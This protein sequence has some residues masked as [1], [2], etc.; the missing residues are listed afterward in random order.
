MRKSALI[1]SIF[2]ILNILVMVLI[3]NIAYNSLFGVYFFHTY[4]NPSEWAIYWGTSLGVLFSI[5]ITALIALFEFNQNLRINELN[6]ITEYAYNILNEIFDCRH[7]DNQKEFNINLSKLKYS[8][9]I[10]KNI[11]FRTQKSQKVYLQIY[12]I[13][14]I[15]IEDIFRICNNYKDA[16]WNE[17][18][19]SY[20]LQENVSGIFKH[21]SDIDSILANRK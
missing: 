19:K 12:E 7:F 15:I 14:N 21:I 16:I 11:N 20:F 5:I 9:I 2:L 1:L 6:K 17:S 13:L 10:R 4:L 8:F 18:I 3:E